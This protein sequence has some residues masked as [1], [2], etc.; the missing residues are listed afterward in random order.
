MKGLYRIT[1]KKPEQER[2]MPELLTEEEEA[3]RG[4]PESAEDNNIRFRIA[5][6]S[7]NEISAN[8]DTESLSANY[9]ERLVKLIPAEVISLY[10]IGKGVIPTEE[11]T[12]IIVWAIICTIGVLVSRIYGTQSDE[13]NSIQWGTVVI[14]TVSFLIWLY[15][16]GDAFAPFVIYVP[17][18]GTLMMAAWTF[19]VPYFYKGEIVHQ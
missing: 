11:K 8:P 6:P 18:I 10:L 5:T 13:D 3:F 2:V 9:L 15:V 17:W 12:G 19:F 14:T 16:I 4:K 1:T 7:P